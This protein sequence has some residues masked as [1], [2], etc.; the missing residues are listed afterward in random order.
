MNDA[1]ASTTR[2]VIEP[3]GNVGIGTTSPYT[4]LGVSGE[5]VAASFTATTTATSTFSGGFSTN[6]LN[7]TSTTASSTLANGVNLTTGCF[8]I[9]GSCVGGGGGSGT[10]TSVDA[11]GGTTGLSFT[12][13]PITSSGTLT[14]SGTLAV[15]N[16]GTN[17]TSQTTNGVNFF[18]GTSITSGT[19]LT[20]DGT[21]LGIG[22]ST[23]YS[24]LGV[25]GLGTGAGQLFSLVDNASSTVLQVLDNGNVGIGTTTPRW[26]LHVASST[27]YLAISDTDAGVNAKHWLV[28]APCWAFSL[29]TSSDS[30]IANPYAYLTIR[31]GGDVAIGTTTAS[32]QLTIRNNGNSNVLQMFSTT[33]TSL[34][35]FTNGGTFSGSSSITGQTLALNPTGSGASVTLT[36]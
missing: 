2:F 9:N 26:S 6:L 13:G 25:W 21:N 30:L 19:A 23:P 11:S 4:K 35:A 22:T 10:V 32:S 1:L 31:E 12:G 18:N 15:A 20:F 7:V 5:V 17:A 27:P 33:G 24:R 28:S 8:S 36:A 29:G 14:L 34:F 3:S 16:G